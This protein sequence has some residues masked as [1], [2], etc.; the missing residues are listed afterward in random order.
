MSFMIAAGCDFWMPVWT[1]AQGVFRSQSLGPG[2][3]G[4]EWRCVSLGGMVGVDA[5]NKTSMELDLFP[6]ATD[7]FFQV[8]TTCSYNLS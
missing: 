1:L 7:P 5:M 8:A 4:A 2:Y 3:T 6:L